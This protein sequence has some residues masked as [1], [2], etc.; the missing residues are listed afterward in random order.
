MNPTS[1]VC[2]RGQR[3]QNE[4]KVMTKLM[5]NGHEGG[6]PSE[7]DRTML[8]KSP[9]AVPLDAPDPVL[10]IQVDEPPSRLLG[11]AGVGGTTGVETQ[12]RRF[13]AHGQ[14]DCINDGG[15]LG[16]RNRKSIEIRKKYRISRE[17]LNTG[18]MPAPRSSSDR[19]RI[20]S[21]G[22][23]RTVSHPRDRNA[24]RNSLLAVGGGAV[25]SWIRL[26]GRNRGIQTRDLVRAGGVHL[27]GSHPAV[28]E[29]HID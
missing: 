11:C 18:L 7:P 25:P 10:T 3:V 23:V 6:R 8:R 22:H 28:L 21:C 14:A 20:E 19:L 9:V 24:V 27:L 13:H 1:S 16:I 17:L 29:P 15:H 5:S 4:H 26:P 2:R 12:S